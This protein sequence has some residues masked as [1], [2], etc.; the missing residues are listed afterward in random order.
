MTALL[1]NYHANIELLFCI[2]G[3]GSV[4]CDSHR[5][6]FAPGDIAVINSNTLHKVESDDCV[7]YYCLIVDEEFCFS[8][9]I[10]VSKISFDARII[11]PEVRS[12]FEAVCKAFASRE[13]TKVVDVRYCVLGLLLILLRKYSSP[14]NEIVQ[15]NTLAA[16]KRIKKVV[17]YIQGNLNT[18]I[19]LDDISKHI[20][21]SKFHL[22]RDFKKFTGNTIFEYIN[23]SRCNTAAILIA[24]GMSVSAAAV[25]CG[26]ENMSYFSRTYKKYMGKLP[27]ADM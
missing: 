2:E 24:G 14:V 7:R 12:A 23:M 4:I 25:E 10:D 6:D 5:Y 26:F 1:P 13:E 3:C 27:S 17:E 20:G 8:N 9:G 19:T 22:S 18:N 16:G 21:I 11:D 15:K